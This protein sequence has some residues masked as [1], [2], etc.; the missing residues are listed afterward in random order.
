MKKLILYLTIGLLVATTAAPGQV[1]TLDQ[2]IDRAL[3]NKET[4]KAAALGVKAAEYGKRGA[5]SNILPSLGAG[6]GYSMSNFKERTNYA[7]GT[8]YSS[9]KGTSWGLQLTQPVYDGG[10]WWNS[11]AGANNNYLIS[12][13]QER[14]VRIN[15]IYGVIQAYYSLLKAQQLL[16]VARMNLMLANQQVELVTNQFEIGAAAKTDLLKVNVLKGQ[17]QVDVIA[18]DAELQ[19]AT[20]NLRNAIGLMDDTDPLLVDESA[21]GEYTVPEL[22]PALNE[23]TNSNPSILAKKAQIGGAI[24]NHKIIRGSRLPNISVGWRYNYQSAD[25][26]GLVADFDWSSAISLELSIPLFTGFDLSTRTQQAKLNIA[27]EEYEFTTQLH[28]LRV[29]LEGLLEILRNYRET[30]PINEEVLVSAEEDLKLVQEQYALGSVTILEVLDAQL[31][32]TRAR[33]SLVSYKYDAQ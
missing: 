4:V 15:V 6:A 3:K 12:Q 26:T 33:S 20:R 5:L 24:L 18:R 9:S 22:L 28:D 25:V 30:I 13:Q 16:D 17:A 32:V 14:Q 27:N 21:G 29:Q 7:T 31:S 23:M 8:S 19:N 10:A 1:L 11:I 2:C